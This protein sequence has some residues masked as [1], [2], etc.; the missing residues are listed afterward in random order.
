MVR[1]HLPRGSDRSAPAQRFVQPDVLRDQWPPFR[2]KRLGGRTNVRPASQRM[3]ASKRP[4][5]LHTYDHVR[6]FSDRAGR[7]RHGL[8]L[9]KRLN[10]CLTSG[11]VRGFT[12]ASVEPNVRSERSLDIPTVW[13]RLVVNFINGAYGSSLHVQTWRPNKPYLQS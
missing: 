6:V 7:Q 3:A 9:P 5:L 4:G 11:Y 8:K 10:E 12:G 13:P 1:L 2:L